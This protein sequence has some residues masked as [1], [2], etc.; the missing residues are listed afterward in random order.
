MVYTQQ[1]DLSAALSI[2]N[3]FPVNIAVAYLFEEKFIRESFVTHLRAV[4]SNCDAVAPSQWDQLY[5]DLVD[6]FPLDCT[7]RRYV[8]QEEEATQPQE[9]DGES[10]K[11]PPPQ[12]QPAS[13]GTAPPPRPK[14]QR[15]EQ[16][17]YN[18]APSLQ[19][20][21]P[22]QQGAG[23]VCNPLHAVPAHTHRMDVVP[24]VVL[25]VRC[26]VTKQHKQN[27]GHVTGKGAKPKAPGLRKRR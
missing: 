16:A 27:G 17:P 19:Q 13:R 26:L 23:H 4:V 20:S 2:Q 12:S 21:L 1:P 22:T 9:E 18:R 10:Q 11:R 8:E 25:K 6:G 5:E 24:L 3:M 7:E 14:N 15:L